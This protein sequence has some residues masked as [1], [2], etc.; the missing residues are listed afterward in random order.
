[1][2]QTVLEPGVL[3]IVFRGDQKAYDLAV[4]DSTLQ[5]TA[6]RSFYNNME[7]YREYLTDFVFDAGAFADDLNAVIIE[8]LRAAQ[9]L[10]GDHPYLTRLFTT[11]SADE[12]TVDPMFAFNPDLPDV[13]NIRTADARLECP[14]GDPNEINFEEIVLVV[15]LKDGREIRSFPYKNRPPGPTLFRS[16]AAVVEQMDTAGDPVLVRGLAQA[17]PDFDGSGTVDFDDFV[18]FA[19]AYGQK[20]SEFD[21]T[22]DG[23]VDFSDFIVFA[24]S[25]GGNAN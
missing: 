8:P 3:A 13:S 11:L 22:G 21:L 10:L 23:A 5:A 6:E 2:S 17:N 7:S 4:A 19:G 15:T 16:A 9:N 20:N 18:M 24:R 14:E 1:M 25:Y 12:M